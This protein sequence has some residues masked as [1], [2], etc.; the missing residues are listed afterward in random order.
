M[1][2]GLGCYGLELP[3]WPDTEPLL[4]PAASGWPYLEVSIAPLPD[5]L[6]DATGVAPSEAEVALIGGRLRMQRDPLQAEFFLDRPI[7]SGALVHPYLALAAGIACHWLGRQVFH[8]GAFIA[9]GGA[10]AILAEK[11]GGKSSTLAWLD[12]HGYDV[13]ADDLLVVTD[14]IA[15]AGPRCID[16]R[17][18]TAN[19]L[20]VGDRLDGADGR[21]RWRLVTR[22]TQTAAPLRGWIVPEW[23]E[24]VSLHPVPPAERLACVL[25]HRSVLSRSE[26][27]EAFLELAARPC[28]RFARPHGLATMG[29]AIE[30]MLA[31]LPG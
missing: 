25:G 5:A 2:P 28:L 31:G 3:D 18:T 4:I 15:L 20:G 27:Q 14:G 10:W 9:D 13:L 8:A 6:P 1:S 22:A 19:A 26:D 24:D 11:Q 12:G 21:D 16:L 23:A 17:T 7:D 30:A 29:A